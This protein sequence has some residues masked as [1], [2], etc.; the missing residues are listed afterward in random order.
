MTN[1]EL[2][3]PPIERFYD[4]SR[5]SEAGFEADIAAD[6]EDRAGLAA[7]ASVARVDK[8]E[9]RV[10]LQ[11]LAPNRFSYRAQLVAEIVQSCTVTLEPV[12]SRLNLEFG[13]TLHLVP[14]FKKLA[15]TLG[16]ELGNGAGDDEAPDEIDDPLFDLAVPLLEEF[17]LAIDPYPRA[18]GVAFEPAPAERDWSESP[19][20]VLKTLKRGD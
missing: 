20:A 14:H 2:P 18:P 7:W 3:L 15:E 6:T 10:A 5:L 13:R 11:R 12:S 17:V 8:F 9:A 16:G 4:L 19:F 1:P